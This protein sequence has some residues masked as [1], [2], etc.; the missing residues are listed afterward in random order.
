MAKKPLRKISKGKIKVFKI[1]N[2]RG[3][4]AVCQN[5]L[6]EGRTVDQALQRMARPLK[7]QGYLLE[8]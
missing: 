3:F 8:V 7:R 2:R 6:T 4:A 5:N 1:C